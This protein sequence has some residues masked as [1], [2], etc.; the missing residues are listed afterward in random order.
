V[1]RAMRL[2]LEKVNPLAI[3]GVLVA[4]VLCAAGQISGE[5]TMLFV[6]GVCIKGHTDPS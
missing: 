3:L 4:C 5:A 1:T 2:Q 6:S